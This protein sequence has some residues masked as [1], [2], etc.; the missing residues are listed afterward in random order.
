MEESVKRSEMTILPWLSAGR[1]H[2]STFCARAANINNSSA[3]GSSSW[4]AGSSRMRRICWPMGE[5]PG[6]TLSRTGRPSPRRRSASSRACVIVPLPSGP[7]KVMKRP[8][9]LVVDIVQDLLQVLPRFLLRVLIVGPQ[10]IG[11]MVGDHQL[12]VAPFVPF[13]AHPRHAFRGA[14]QSLGGGGA[15]CANGLGFDRL[16][17]PVKELSANFHLVGLRRAILWRPALHHVADVDVGALDRNAFLRGRTLNHL[18]EKLSRASHKRQA[19]LIFI[20]SGT[21]TN[22]YQPGFLVARPE[23]DFMASLVQTAALAIADVLNDRKQRVLRGFNGRQGHN[24]G[25]WLVAGWQG[26]FECGAT[27]YGLD[28]EILVELQALAKLVFGHCAACR[29]RRSFST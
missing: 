16:Q 1:I 21:F 10:Q 26:T 23:Y 17:L 9:L 4:L 13:P 11:G 22:K 2:C 27:K 29:A 5:P 20:G 7:S 14:E 12:N 18:R 24:G 19:L 28:S 15:Q 25:W 8:R 6:S 3:T